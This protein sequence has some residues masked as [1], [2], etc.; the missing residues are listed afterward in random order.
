MPLQQAVDKGKTYDKCRQGNKK[1][2]NLINQP[3]QP[4]NL[5]LRWRNP[6]QM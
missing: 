5:N 1:S 2:M 4:K 6:R 3:H